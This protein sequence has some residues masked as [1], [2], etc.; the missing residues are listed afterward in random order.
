MVHGWLIGQQLLWPR[1]QLLSSNSHGMNK[2]DNP[3]SMNNYIA[4]KINQIVND[5]SICANC[6]SVALK[7]EFL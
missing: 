6:V 7:Q 2:N 5:F 4:W 1:V 3:F